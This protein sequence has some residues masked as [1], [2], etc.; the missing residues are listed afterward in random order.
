VKH[1]VFNFIHHTSSTFN[2]PLNLVC[3]VDEFSAFI[4]LNHFGLIATL[5][6]QRFRNGTDI[7]Y[8]QLF[9]WF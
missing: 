2:K 3:Q 5:I 6:K 7:Y 8:S 4:H 1:A 9:T